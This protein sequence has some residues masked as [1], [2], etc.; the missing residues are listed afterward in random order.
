VVGRA[1]VSFT[2]EAEE[3]LLDENILQDDSDD[4]NTEH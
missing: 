1:P 3:Q 4:G 2:P